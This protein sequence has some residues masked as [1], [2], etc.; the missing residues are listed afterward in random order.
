MY[1]MLL[2]VFMYSSVKIMP[3]VMPGWAPGDAASLSEISARG[4]VNDDMLN[5][6]CIFKEEKRIYHHLSLFQP[7]LEDCFCWV[8]AHISLI[9]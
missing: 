4:M 2:C 6:C 1:K 8:C 9:G 7:I 3:P 5:G